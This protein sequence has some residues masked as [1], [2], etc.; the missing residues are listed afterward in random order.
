MSE[1]APS[2]KENAPLAEHLLPK[3]GEFEIAAHSDHE[4]SEAELAGERSH[5]QAES[6]TIAAS[7]APRTNPLET[8]HAQQSA[9]EAPTPTLITPDL[10]KATKTR[11]LK[12]IQRQLKP[13]DKVLS[14]VI[15]QPVIRTISEGASRTVSRPSGLLGGG[16]VAFVGTSA[17]LYFTKHIGLRYNYLIFAMLF[18]G[19]FAIGLILEFLVWSFSARRRRSD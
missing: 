7:E 1:T 3:G 12:Q 17:Y 14:K 5:M 19:G 15:H 2:N 6:R 16:L 4:P 18:I 13:T 8:F 11:Q 10:K 9:Q